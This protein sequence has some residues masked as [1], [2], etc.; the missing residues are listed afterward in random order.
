MFLLPSIQAIVN[1]HWNST[2]VQSY[3]WFCQIIPY[4]CQLILFILWTDVSLPLTVAT[5]P[6]FDT[7][8]ENLLIAITSYFLLVKFYQFSRKG[9][10]Y[11]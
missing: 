11:L 3:L 8:L 2:L 6:M 5:T 10:A 4:V 9:L 1:F 7:V